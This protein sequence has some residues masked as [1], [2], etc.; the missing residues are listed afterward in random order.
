MIDT[1][2]NNIIEYNYIVFS[3]KEILNI[4][5][6]HFLFSESLESI[7]KNYETGIIVNMYDGDKTVC[8]KFLG[9]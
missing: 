5:Y 2:S 6:Y 3:F 8:Y 7:W 9:N 1:S 4:M